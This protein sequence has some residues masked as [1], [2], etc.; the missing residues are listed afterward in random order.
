IDTDAMVERIK[1]RYRANGALILTRKQ[2]ADGEYYV[3]EQI[4][5]IGS[6]QDIS[7]VKRGAGGIADEMIITGSKKV[8]K[9]ISEYNIRRILCD[10]ESMVL[11]QD[12]KRVAAKTLL[13]SAFFVIETGKS[14]E[15]VIGYTLTGGGYGHGV[16]MSQNGAKEMGSLGYDYQEILKSFFADCEVHE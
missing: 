1:E 3:S 11:R 13:P 12:G 14:G 5:D 2:N 15:D 10:G 6:L 7:I 4:D 9:V 16:G 8:I